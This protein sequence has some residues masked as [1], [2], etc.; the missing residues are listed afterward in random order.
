MTVA[1]KSFMRWF[2]GRTNSVFTRSRQYETVLGEMGIVRER[3][4]LLPP[5]VDSE[6]FSPRHRDPNY[7]HDRR[8]NEPYHLL[9]CG[10]V[11]TEKNLGV[12]ADSFRQLCKTRPDVA[13]VVAGDGP[14]MPALQKQLADLPAYFLGRLK[15]TELAPLYANSDL[16]LFPS[17]TDT[18][19]QVVL[20]AQSSGLPVL[21]SD[22]GG[23][24]EVMDDGLTGMVLPATDASAWTT[25]IDDLLNDHARRLRM[26]RTAPLRVAR[27][28]PARTFDTYWDEHVKAAQEA[29]ERH[30]AAALPVPVSTAPH[31]QRSEAAAEASVA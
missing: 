18:L 17:R 26:S 22:E 8:M 28:S 24:N 14:Q 20:E 1:A 19:G 11:S 10:R 3:L 6:T 29:A 7:W 16:L 27:C 4:A 2:Y 9:Y 15:D 12:L 23:P 5:C 13:L 31:R 25:A 21:V 30:A